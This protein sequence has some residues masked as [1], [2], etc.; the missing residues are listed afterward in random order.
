MHFTLGV[1]YDDID[2]DEKSIEEMRTVIRLNPDHAN[3]LNYLGY[4]F[5]EKGINLDEAEKLIKKALSL[6]P[7][8]G[9]MIDS[10]GWV[11]YKKGD[12]DRAVVELERAAKYI[13]EDPIVAEHLGDAY[14][15]KGLKE[16]A[17]KY[18]EISYTLDPKNKSLQ[19]KLEKLRMEIEKGA[20]PKPTSE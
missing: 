17:L 1:L 5:A 16:K 10:L 18:F 20:H 4:T 15:K 2:E 6:K 3:A 14:Y 11:Y 19:E 9:P 13:P 8:S 12:F 7:D